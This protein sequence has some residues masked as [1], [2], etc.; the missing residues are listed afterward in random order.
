MF[1]GPDAAKEGPVQQ[2]A[3]LQESLEMWIGEDAKHDDQYTQ[4]ASFTANVTSSRIRERNVVCSSCP[5]PT[6][7]K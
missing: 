7:T 2:K 4:R 6:K 5:A 1:S 3:I